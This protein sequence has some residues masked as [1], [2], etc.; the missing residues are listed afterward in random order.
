MPEPSQFEQFDLALDA[1]LSGSAQPEAADVELRSL[2]AVARDLRDL[3]RESFKSRLKLE[4]ERKSSMATYAEPSV[5]RQGQLETATPRLRV[6]NAAAAIDFYIRAFGA[7]EL[8]RFDVHG[9]IAYAE[10]AFGH[11]HVSVG[12]EDAGGGYPGPESLG[13]SPV[14]LTLNVPDSDAAVRQAVAA[15]ATLVRPVTDQFY[16]SRDGSVLDPFGYTWSLSTRKEELSVGEMHRR[17][18]AMMVAPEPKPAVSPVPKG[19]HTITPY[20]VAADAAALLDFVRDTFGAE[21]RF[22]TIGSAGG[23]HAE[24]QIGDSML[25][26]GG[27]G[28]GL[29]FSGKALPTAMHVYV[30]DCDAVH[31]RG[32]AAGGVTIQPPADHEYGERSGSLKD[33]AGNN[34]YIAT[35]KGSSYIPEGFHTVTVSLHPRRAEPVLQFV[36]RGLGG[37]DVHKYALPDGVIPHATVRI[38]DSLLE[39]GEAHGPYQPMPTMFYLYVPNC[40]ELYQRALSAGAKSIS[41][42][43]DHE[44]GDRSAAV[45]DVFGNQWYIA[46]HFKDVTP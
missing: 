8:M 34:W 41:A 33:P 36:Q 20:I 35:Y 38:G 10:L 19:Y 11:S 24:T 15:G 39:M 28:P 42:P 32:V 25:M 13:G 40:D 2:L 1:L 31:A 27:G 46:T 23:I 16:G 14:A 18:D 37:R 12:E 3:P 5:E 21:E 30:E 26:V 44:Y 9:Q 45:E 17:F 7:R 22:R 43:V 6:R 4:I 29:K